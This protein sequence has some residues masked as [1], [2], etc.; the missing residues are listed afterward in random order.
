MSTAVPLWT[1]H[2]TFD[3]IGMIF[4]AGAAFGNLSSSTPSLSVPASYPMGLLELQNQEAPL[5]VCELK[6]VL[7]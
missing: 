5:L 1:T 4:L 2:A 3:P 6:V 7:L